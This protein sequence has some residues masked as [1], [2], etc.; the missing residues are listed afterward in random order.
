MNLFTLRSGAHSQRIVTHAVFPISISLLQRS[1]F[2]DFNE[3]HL[4][5]F[6]QEPLF[7]SPFLSIALSFNNLITFFFQIL[8]HFQILSSP[9]KL[10]T[11]NNGFL[12]LGIFFQINYFLNCIYKIRNFICKRMPNN[13]QIKP[14]GK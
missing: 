6:F 4:H 12:Y 8:E 13:K 5:S 10:F 11:N 9:C 7:Q 14:K 2:T 3:M 1:F